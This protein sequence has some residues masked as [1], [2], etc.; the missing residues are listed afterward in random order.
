[1]HTTTP[2]T[3]LAAREA[4]TAAKARATANPSLRNDPATDSEVQCLTDWEEA[5]IDCARDGHWDLLTMEELAMAAELHDDGQPD[6]RSACMGRCTRDATIAA[7]R[8]R[9]AE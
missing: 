6:I 8:I 1:M 3:L 7:I 4:F 9:L 5:I 2:M